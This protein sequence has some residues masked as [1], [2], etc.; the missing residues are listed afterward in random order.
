MRLCWQ[1]GHP[2]Q[3]W[4]FAALLPVAGGGLVTDEP[5]LE[6]LLRR[7]SLGSGRRH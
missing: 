4:L 6:E 1:E 3:R 2:D 7:V 5:T